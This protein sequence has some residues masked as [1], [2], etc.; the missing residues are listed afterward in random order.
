M[1]MIT[2][3]MKL[4]LL[5]ISMIVI[6]FAFKSS[7]QSVDIVGPT[8]NC[9]GTPLTLS[10]NINGLYPPF[11]YLWSTGDTT[12]TITITNNAL[13][14]VRVS[15]RNPLIGHREKVFS[16]YRIFIFF[17]SPTATISASGPTTLCTGGTVDLT[18]DGGGFLS[19]YDWSNGN[20]TRTITV[21]TT[22]DYS[23]TITNIFGCSSTSPVEHVTNFNGVANITPD[24]PLTFCQPGSINL[25]GD[26]GLDTYQWSTGETTQSISVALTGTVG[27]VL[28]TQTVVLTVTA[29]TC[30]A[31]SNPVVV[32]SIRQTQLIDAYCPNFT[33]ALSTDSIKNG[34]ILPFNGI[35]P[36]YEFE[37]TETTN[38][39]NVFTAVAT[40]TRYLR[41][42]DVPQLVVGKFYLV[43]TRG[44]I[45]GT[46][47][48]Y[49]GTCQIGIATNVAA[50][51]SS[52]RIIIDA[53]DGQ[54]IVV[55]DGINFNIYPNPSNN[56]FTANIF[57]IDENPIQVNVTDMT[58]RIITSYQTSAS[59]KQFIFGSELKAGIYLVEFTQGN[60]RQVT[61]VVKTN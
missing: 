29:G 8:F 6:I 25:S 42:T 46:R 41:L 48:C 51:G 15:G 2:K 55:R 59:D 14:R 54:K 31:T 60:L 30:S 33:L 44:I 21:S 1:K 9:Q 47:F 26:A 22:G 49:G 36:D 23:V 24:G 35:Y 13:V 34:L 10:V 3:I 20:T 52:E 43:R 58:G 11:R 28:D 37:F 4:R 39:S 32:R 50:P 61:R 27:T 17:P 40:Q 12:S 16:P 18:A 57:T 45:D 19:T 53:E 5:F 38:P 7:A 56:N